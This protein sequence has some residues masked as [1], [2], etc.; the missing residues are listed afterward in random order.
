MSFSKLSFLGLPTLGLVSLVMPMS[1]TSV[2]G[3][4]SISG[5]VTVTATTINFVPTFSTQGGAAA[6]TGSF[7]GLTGGVYNVSD[8]SFRM[9]LFL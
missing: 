6:Q 5:S 7:S 1:A 2:T 9:A 3:G 8:I 4:A